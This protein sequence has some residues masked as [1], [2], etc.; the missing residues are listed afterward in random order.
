[1]PEP[2]P[3]ANVQGFF[4]QK[5]YTIED[6]EDVLV[7]WVVKQDQSFAD[8]ESKEFKGILNMIKPGIKLPSADTLKRRIMEG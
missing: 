1:M 8:I 3:T 6:L 2:L 5:E 7:K 4:M